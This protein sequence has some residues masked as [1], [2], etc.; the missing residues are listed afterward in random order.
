MNCC[1]LG[2]QNKPQRILNQSTILSNWQPCCVGIN[3]IMSMSVLMVE[4]VSDRA[5]LLRMSRVIA[6]PQVYIYIP[7]SARVITTHIAVHDLTD[8]ITYEYI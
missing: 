3:V 6:D 8:R 7:Q 2:S 1:Q 5:S 4:Q